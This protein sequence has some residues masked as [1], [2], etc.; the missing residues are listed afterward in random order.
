MDNSEPIKSTTDTKVKKYMR[1]YKKKQY[2]ESEEFREKLKVTRKKHYIKLATKD[3]PIN[4]DG[5]DVSQLTLDL[6]KTIKQIE[7][8]AQ[9]TPLLLKS[10]ITHYNNNIERRYVI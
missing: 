9:S 5:L 6:I 8:V 7:K 3:Q 10:I 4:I 1:E 2:A